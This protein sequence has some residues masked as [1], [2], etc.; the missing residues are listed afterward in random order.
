MIDDYKLMKSLKKK[1]EKSFKTLYDN[2][3]R[4]VYYQAY[5]VLKNNE[6]SEDVTQQVFIRFFNKIDELPLDLNIKAYLVKLSNNAAIDLYRK[7]KK[8]ISIENVDEIASDDDTKN[9]LL[10]FNGLLEE[11]EN[12]ILILRLNF[13]YSFNEISLEMNERIGTIQ[14]KYYKALKKIKKYYQEEN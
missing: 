9:M 2:Y 13:D 4:L 10:N 8:E 11:D 7:N 3:Y 5:L 1:T 14:S 12:K 6:D